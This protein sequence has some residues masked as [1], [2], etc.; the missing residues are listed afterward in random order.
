MP[1]NNRAALL[2]IAREGTAPVESGNGL[3]EDGETVNPYLA[4]T[5]RRELE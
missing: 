1:T 2:A 3:I 4:G 5:L